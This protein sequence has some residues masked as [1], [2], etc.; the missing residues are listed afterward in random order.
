[1]HK[2]KLKNSFKNDKYSKER[3]KERKKDREEWKKGRNCLL[4]IN[5]D[6]AGKEIKSGQL[7]DTIKQMYR[8]ST[9]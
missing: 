8:Q 1:M 2:Q 3:K 7:A 4:V 6:K 5:L 9:Q